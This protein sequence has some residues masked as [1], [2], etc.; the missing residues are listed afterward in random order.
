MAAKRKMNVKEKRGIKSSYNSSCVARTAKGALHIAQQP[1]QLHLP[2]NLSQGFL[3]HS[4]ISQ[5]PRN[6]ENPIPISS[7][8]APTLADYE[9]L[10]FYYGKQRILAVNQSFC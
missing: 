6:L 4:G 7:L 5:G 9:K 2:N 1:S 8:L 10:L 3:L